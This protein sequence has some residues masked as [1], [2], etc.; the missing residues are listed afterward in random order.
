MP[1]ISVII[2]VYN[3]ARYVESA[4]GSILQQSFGDF[5][6]VAVDDG[7]TDRTKS[8]LDQI[9]ARDP[10]VRIISRP[11]TGIVGALNDAL[12]AA[13][14][15]FI[16]RMDAD[17]IA[18]PDRFAEQLAYL[19]AHPEC[20]ALGTDILYTDPDGAPLIRHRPALAHD[21]IVAQLYEANG[22]AIIHPTMMARRAVIEQIGR[23]RPETR[24]FLEDLDLYLRLSDVGKLA[25]L[26]EV[27]LHY[28][29][30]LQSINRMPGPRDLLRQQIVNPYRVRRG[31]PPFGPAAPDPNAPR[32]AGDWYRHWAFEAARGG[33]PRS[34]RKNALRA[35]RA[36]IS[37]GRNWRCLKYVWTAPAVSSSP[38]G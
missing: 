30:H 4:L 38:H 17:D 7:S 12:A 27:H 15:E 16:A 1:L 20:V 13:Q 11:N 33:N 14:G 35:C 3:A 32:S 6:L 8:V 9:A 36:A 21:T 2:P 24:N 29:Q 34:A 37:D 25:N 5:E 26:P 19:R 10:R 31:L 18:L 28:R 23:Y 22:G